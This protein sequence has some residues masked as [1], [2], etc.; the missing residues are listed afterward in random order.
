MANQVP[1]YI[2]IHDQLKDE[3]EKGVWKVGDRLPSERELSVKF[4]VSRMTLRQAIQT[5]ADEGILERKI[6]SGTYV[7]NEKVQEKMSGTTSFTDIMESQNRTPSSKTISFFHSP[8][9]SSEAENLGLTKGD[10]ILRMERIRYADN[11]PICFEVAS[12]PAKIVKGFSKEEITDSFYH[13]L[14]QKGMEIGRANQTVSAILASEQIADYLQIKR[15]EAILRLR[16]I[17][18]LADDQPFE[19]VRTQYVGSRFEFYLEK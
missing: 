3:I 19:Y 6:G 10:Q 1:I 17:S 4:K 16:Q 15:G 13:T 2:Q 9:S 5:L 12:I 7:A 8:A 11:I 18:Y 14:K